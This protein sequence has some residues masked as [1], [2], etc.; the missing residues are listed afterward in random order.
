MRRILV[1]VCIFFMQSSMPVLATPL[2]QDCSA[3]AITSPRSSGDP[4]RGRLA[5]SGSASIPN[6]QFYKVEYAPGVN[7]ADSSFRSI[8]PDVHRNEVKSGQLE[9]WDTTTVPD[10]AYVLRLTVV[11]IRGNFPCPPV[12]VRQVIVANRTPLATSTATPTETTAPTS[13][14]LATATKPPPPTIA[15]P[16]SAARGTITATANLTDPIPSRPLFSFDFL[17]IG[18]ALAW[19]VCGMGGLMALIALLA[20]AR[21]V[22]D[23][24]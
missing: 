13:A 6:F 24:I 17:A 7:P 18:E 23:Q 11:D 16:T 3:V 21:W 22:L 12:I 2:Q 8:A 10:G 19:G 14:P 20:L 5:I 9:V 15:V 4:V 1:M